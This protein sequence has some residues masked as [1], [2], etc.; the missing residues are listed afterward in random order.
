MAVV[1]LPRGALPLPFSMLLAVY[2]EVE[3]DFVCVEMLDRSQVA[4]FGKGDCD[5]NVDIWR[6]AGDV[7]DY[8]EALIP[9]R[10]AGRTTPF[11]EAIPP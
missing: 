9:A 2:D 8:E 3:Y 6:Q 1:P 5:A 11:P 7:D 10:A 4:I